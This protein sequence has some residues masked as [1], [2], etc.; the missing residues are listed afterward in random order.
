[1]IDIL[2]EIIARKYTLP[3]IFDEGSSFSLFVIVVT[4]QFIYNIKIFLLQNSAIIQVY[5]LIS[6]R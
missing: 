5:G 4:T 2:N 1:M 3:V 6:N